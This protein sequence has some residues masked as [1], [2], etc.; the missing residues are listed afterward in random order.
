MR[1]ESSFDAGI[2]S[3]AGAIGLMQLMPATARQITGRGQPAPDLKNP[4]ENMR[5]GI[6]YFQGLLAQFGGVRPYAIAAYNAGPHRARAW[7]TDNGDAAASASAADMIDWIEEIPY[8]ET[9]NYVQR[10]LENSR[11]YAAHAAR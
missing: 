3:G 1:Q 7:V 6:A 2:V 10:V 11:I 9:R 5:L 8:G 4:H